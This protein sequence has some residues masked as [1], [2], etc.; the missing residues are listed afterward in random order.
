[1]EARDVTLDACKRIP[2]S[3]LEGVLG[4]LVELQVAADI[5][6]RADWRDD[7]LPIAGNVAAVLLL[8]IVPNISRIKA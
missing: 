2:E 4:H 5:G 3:R 1:M 8:A 7:P 6:G